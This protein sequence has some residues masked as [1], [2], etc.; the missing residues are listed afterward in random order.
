MLNTLYT[1][2]WAWKEI[3]HPFYGNDRNIKQYLEPN[4]ECYRRHSVALQPQIERKKSSFKFT[5]TINCF[6]VPSLHIAGNNF[7]ALVLILL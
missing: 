6:S 2:I 4:I 7:P 5:V 1:E 3:S